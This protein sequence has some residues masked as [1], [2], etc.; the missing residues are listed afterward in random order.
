MLGIQVNAKTGAFALAFLAG[1]IVTSLFLIVNVPLD[2]LATPTQVTQAEFMGVAAFFLISVSMAEPARD[3]FNRRMAPLAR[4]LQVQVKVPTPVRVV[5]LL[6]VVW[7][8]F[9]FAFW[10]IACCLG[11]YNGYGYAFSN[12]PIL[13]LVY[14]HTIG[15]VPY[16]SQRDKGTQASFWLGVGALGLIAFR[17]NRGIGTALKDTLTLFVAPAIILYELGLWYSAPE[18]MTWHVTDYLTLGGVADGGWRSFDKGA[19]FPYTPSLPYVVSNWFVLFVCL[20]LVAYRIPWIYMAAS[21]FKESLAS[22]EPRP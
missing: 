20:C 15:L 19:Y 22:P 18:D 6:L 14:Y 5:A 13:P 8:A 4:L 16:L 17:A 2:T 7:G 1:S 21:S 12:Y 3:L 9:A 10:A 11:G